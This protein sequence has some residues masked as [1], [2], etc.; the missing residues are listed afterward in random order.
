[1]HK[2]LFWSSIA[3]IFL[4]SIL[5]IVGAWVFVTSNNKSNANVYFIIGILM[6]ASNLLW[7]LASLKKLQ[8]KRPMG[9][10]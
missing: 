10:L 5:N 9:R 2:F 7:F 3:G 4:G 6:I 8:K 1:M